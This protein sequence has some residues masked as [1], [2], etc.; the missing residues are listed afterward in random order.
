[1]D[2]RMKVLAA[3]TAS[4]CVIAASSTHASPNS[5]AGAHH[6]LT[7]DDI[8]MVAPG[9]DKYVR[10]MRAKQLAD[11]SAGSEADRFSPGARDDVTRRITLHWHGAMPNTAMTHIAIQEELNGKVVDWMERVTDEQYS[12]PCEK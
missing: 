2:V 8:R 7:P 3:V 12:G 5:K 1:M 10:G 9:L 6:M 11:A 4:L